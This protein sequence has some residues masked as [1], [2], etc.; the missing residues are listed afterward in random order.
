MHAEETARGAWCGLKASSERSRH[1]ASWISWCTGLDAQTRG[2]SHAAISRSFPWLGRS[3]GA[4]SR[5]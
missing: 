1:R 4:T 3:H 2:T 5:P